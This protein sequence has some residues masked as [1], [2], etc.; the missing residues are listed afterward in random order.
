MKYEKDIE[1]I[2]QEM[3]HGERNQK[4]TE[5][6]QKAKE[7][8]GGEGKDLLDPKTWLYNKNKMRNAWENFKKENESLGPFGQILINNSFGRYM[9]FMYNSYS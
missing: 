6:Y 8:M 4:A 7:E 9:D 5:L 2:K 3:S 1:I